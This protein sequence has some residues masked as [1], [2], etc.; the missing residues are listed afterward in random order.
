MNRIHLY[1]GSDSRLEGLFASAGAFEASREASAVEPASIPPGARERCGRNQ[2]GKS[3][4]LSGW[5]SAL[6]Q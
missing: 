3:K 1:N 5:S 2:A 6:V 4:G